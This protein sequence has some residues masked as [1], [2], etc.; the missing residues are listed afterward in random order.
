MRYLCPYNCLTAAVALLLK[1]Y[2]HTY[3]KIYIYI[4]VRIFFQNNNDSGNNNTYNTN[5][6]NLLHGRPMGSQSDY[7]LQSLNVYKSNWK[8]KKIFPFFF[9]CKINTKNRCFFASFEKNL[10]FNVK[11]KYLNTLSNGSARRDP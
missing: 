6:R 5:S 2:A 4:H 3:M 11:I 7:V 1:R 9:V 10:T 8:K